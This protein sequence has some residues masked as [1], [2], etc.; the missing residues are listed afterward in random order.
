MILTTSLVFLPPYF[1]VISKVRLIS[2]ILH[3]EGLHNVCSSSNDMRL[4]KLKIMGWAEHAV[5][6]QDEESFHPVYQLNVLTVH[7]ITVVTL[8]RHVLA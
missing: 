3:F 7:G 5:D 1:T 2:K 6:E 8:H 4:M